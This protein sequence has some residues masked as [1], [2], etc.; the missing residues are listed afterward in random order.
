MLAAG[1]LLSNLAV[2]SVGSAENV[3]AFGVGQGF[4]VQGSGLESSQPTDE[5]CLT[6]Q[7]HS[8]QS[9]PKPFF[10]WS[11]NSLSYVKFEGPQRGPASRSPSSCVEKKT[12]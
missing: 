1:G 12:Q 3:I 8:L 11:K 6:N 2:G 10:D 9:R 4:R 5:K 7:N